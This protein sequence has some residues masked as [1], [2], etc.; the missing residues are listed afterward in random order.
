MEPVTRPKLA[1]VT[2]LSLAVWLAPTTEAEA[3]PAAISKK[4][5]TDKGLGVGVMVGIP[6][7]LS[8]KYFL[9]P[10]LAVD[11]SLGAYLL[12]RD[13]DGFHAH[14]DLLWHPFVAVEGQTFLAPLYVGLGGRFLTYGETDAMGMD[15]DVSHIGVRIPVGIA[16]V[17]GDAPLDLFLETALIFDPVMSDEADGVVDVNG[18]AGARFFF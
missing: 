5:E 3:A 8:L 12:Y 6:T 7:A 2:A 13:R 1:L 9:T 14:A 11:A 18:L 16:F 4:F 15:V 17:F 10:T